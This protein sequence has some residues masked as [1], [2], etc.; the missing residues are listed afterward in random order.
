MASISHEKKTGRRTV[1]FVGD[2]GKRRSIR[3]GKVNKRQAESAKLFIEDLGTL[4]KPIESFSI[5]PMNSMAR[6]LCHGGHEHGQ[7][8]GIG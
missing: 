3:L 1:Q 7:A 5:W 4:T 2:N 6:N 8:T